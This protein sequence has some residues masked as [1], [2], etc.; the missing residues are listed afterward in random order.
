MSMQHGWPE[1]TPRAANVQQ[2]QCSMNSFWPSVVIQ[3]HR[4][5]FHITRRCNAKCFMK[6]GK[7]TDHTL[8]ANV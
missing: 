2:V 1:P 8:I 3:R 4:L 6:E 7:E 5:N